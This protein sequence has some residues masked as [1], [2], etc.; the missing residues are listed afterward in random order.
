MG[1]AFLGTAFF[2][3]SPVTV[4]AFIALAGIGWASTLTIPFALL[5][6]NM[7]KGTEGSSLGKFNL[8]VAGP[9]ILSSIAVGYLINRNPM[10]IETGS[11]HHWEYALMVGGATALLAALIALTLKKDEK[12]MQTVSDAEQQETPATV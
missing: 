8:F 1:I 9:Q 12:I 3:N 11:T 4:V 2:A 6:D 10:E 7:K 5:M